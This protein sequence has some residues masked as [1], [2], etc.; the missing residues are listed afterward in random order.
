[1]PSLGASPPRVLLGWCITGVR[2]ALCSW[3]IWTQTNSDCPFQTQQHFWLLSPCHCPKAGG[4]HIEI[5]A[6]PGHWL[7][8]INTLNPHMYAHRCRLCNSFEK[9]SRPSGDSAIL[10]PL[11]MLWIN[12]W[13]KANF[14]SMWWRQ[15]RETRNSSGVE[16][17]SA[18]DTGVPSVPHDAD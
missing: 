13:T 7:L 17:N 18:D 15:R 3:S 6:D 5:H 16:H 10:N 1:M 12:E 11:A 14:F 4:R 9:S 8:V 2:Q